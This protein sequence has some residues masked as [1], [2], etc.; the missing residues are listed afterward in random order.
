MSGSPTRLVGS[1]RLVGLVGWPVKHSVSPAMHNA[2][3]DALE[4]DWRYLSLPVPPG[5][6]ETA[7]RGEVA[8]HLMGGNRQIVFSFTF[9]K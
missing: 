2:A 1:T 9:R 7:V 5:Q 6:A 8:K 4:L 3:F